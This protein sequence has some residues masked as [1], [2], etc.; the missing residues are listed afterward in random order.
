MFEILTIVAAL[1][2]LT[3]IKMIIHERKRRLDAAK[4]WKN[5]IAKQPKKE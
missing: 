2:V 3:A 1:S 4:K 5:F